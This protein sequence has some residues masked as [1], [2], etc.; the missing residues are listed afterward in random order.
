MKQS[1]G[2][3]VYR[4]KG[5]LLEVLLV[6]PGGPFWVKKDDGAWSIP[7]G[8][9]LEGED[10]LETAKREFQEET[11]QQIKGTFVPL[12]AI[13]QSKAKTVSVWVVK[14]NIDTARLKSTTFTMEWP[15]HSGQ[16]K[17]FPE[18]DRAAWFGLTAAR[19][20]LLKGQV[21]ILDLLENIVS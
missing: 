19:K 21:P 20:K 18:V 8:E 5:T 9:I 4:K 7:K 2:I 17:E 6:H 11:G 14:G 16:R 13:K 10:P 15:P 12:G 3:V 1:A